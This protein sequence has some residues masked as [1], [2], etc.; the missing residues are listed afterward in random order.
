MSGCSLQKSC[1]YRRALLLTGLA[2]VGGL[3]LY[4]SGIGRPSAQAKPIASLDRHLSSASSTPGELPPSENATAEQPVGHVVQ[5][6]IAVAPAPEQNEPELLAA[7][8][9]VLAAMEIEAAAAGATRSIEHERSRLHLRC[10][11]ELL[12]KGYESFRKVPHY[13]VNFLRQERIE[14]NLHEPEEIQLKVRHE[15]FSVYM[16]WESSDR[17][18]ELL[19]VDGEHDGK[20][21]IRLGGIKGRFMPPISLDPSGSIASERSRYP[22]TQAGILETMKILIR[23][24]KQNLDENDSVRVDFV[25]NRKCNDRDCYYFCIEFLN[26]A[27]SETYRKSIQFI[28]REWNI[29]ICLQNFTWPEESEPHP[30]EDAVS[31]DDATLIEYYS[32]SNLDTELKLGDADFDRSNPEYRFH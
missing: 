3:A 19:Y 32:Y 31:L 28:D 8:S 26:P 5:K 6:P 7:G 20:M 15:P 18:R 1:G 4:A 23:D 27:E 2:A 12:E 22:V 9:A 21:M 16:H 10:N 13:T 14:G 25:E 24:R 11:L 30:G 17:G 29:P